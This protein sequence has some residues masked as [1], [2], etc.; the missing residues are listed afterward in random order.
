MLQAGP[1]QLCYR[2]RGRGLV[3]RCHP[4]PQQPGTMVEF[5]FMSLRGA[6]PA[7]NDAMRDD[8][9]MT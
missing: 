7:L 6:G 9:A 8:D 4:E 2:Q 1:V 3:D 5:G